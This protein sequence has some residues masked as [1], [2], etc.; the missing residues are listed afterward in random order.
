M[1]TER[2][3]KREAGGQPR[4]GDHLLAAELSAEQNMNMLDGIPNN[5]KPRV[6]QNYVIL[7]SERK[8]CKKGYAGG[9]CGGIPKSAKG[10]RR[11]IGLPEA[12]AAERGNPHAGGIYTVCGWESPGKRIKPQAIKTA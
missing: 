7:E 8:R 3:L 1:K 10:R 12:G 11:H 9:D 4:N 6:N 2:E 5:E